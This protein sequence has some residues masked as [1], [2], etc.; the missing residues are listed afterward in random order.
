MATFLDNN[1]AA[2]YANIELTLNFQRFGQS[3]IIYISYDI[4]VD[5]LVGILVGSSV[6]ISVYFGHSFWLIS[7]VDI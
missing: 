1:L 7:K 6:N 5:V 2:L 4:Y 3:L